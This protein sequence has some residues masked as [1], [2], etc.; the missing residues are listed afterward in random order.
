[1][2]L[3]CRTVKELLFN[4]HI[5]SFLSKIK[6]VLENFLVHVVYSS[7]AVFLLVFAIVLPED[8][9]TR[10][11]FLFYP[12]HL[13]TRKWNRPNGHFLA[14]NTSSMLI[15]SNRN[16]RRTKYRL[17]R[18]VCSVLSGSK[19]NGKKVK[20]HNRVISVTKSSPD[21]YGTINWEERA[22]EREEENCV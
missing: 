18:S 19:E 6:N 11:C 5:C 3:K 22:R 14:I 15:S 4:D 1:M 20:F 21:G 16:K 10:Y 8:V 17:Y 7:K 13:F 2:S 9:S 12:R